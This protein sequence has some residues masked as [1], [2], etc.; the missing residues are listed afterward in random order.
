ME[1]EH[2]YIRQAPLSNGWFT[3]LFCFL[4]CKITA[5][6]ASC[7]KKIAPCRQRNAPQTSKV[8]ALVLL[9][10]CSAYTVYICVGACKQIVIWKELK[11]RIFESLFQRRMLKAPQVT[12]IR[13]LHSKCCYWWTLWEF[14]FKSYEHFKIKFFWKQS[15]WLWLWADPPDSGFGTSPLMRYLLSKI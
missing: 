2:V 10:S 1:I 9:C 4:N 8:N 15:L 7:Y 12:F 11:S 6:K 3:S 14:S 13:L 5:P